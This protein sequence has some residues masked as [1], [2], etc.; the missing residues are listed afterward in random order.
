ML[1]DHAE[2]TVRGG[3]G[4]GAIPKKLICSEC[5][6]DQTDGLCEHYGSKS[7]KIFML[8]ESLE[9]EE[10]SFV[11]KPADPF[12]KIVRIHD[13]IMEEIKIDRE[14]NV[15]DC[16]V[17]VMVMKDFFDSTEKTI[18]C[19]DNICTIINQ[20][21]SIM[22]R[23]ADEK[24]TSVALADE[25]GADKVQ[26]LVQG[27]SEVAGKLELTDELTDRQFA[28]VQKT[29]DGLKRRFPLHD[30]LNVRVGLTLFDSAMDL[31]DSE[32]EKV[33]TALEKTAKK[34]GVNLEDF[35]KEQEEEET[36]DASITELLDAAI[37]ELETLCK[38]EATKAALEKR[39]EDA[40]AT[41]E[42]KIEDPI[43]R[44]FGVLQSLAMDF[45]YAG[46]ALEGSITS[47][48]TERGKAAIA[49]DHKDEIEAEITSLKDQVKEL[50]EDVTLLD[51]QNRDLNY[52]IRATLVDEI[53]SSRESLGILED[54]KEAEKEK[55]SK[56]NYDA[57]VTQVNDYRHMKVKLKDSTVNNKVD[58]KTIAD[59][60]L[61]DSV[62]TPNVDQLQDGQPE[63]GGKKELSFKEQVALVK[64]C[65]RRR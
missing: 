42:K 4:G 51:E 53:I 63:D 7:N 3:H 64:A 55:F 13:G 62:E 12:G 26:P 28:L 61:A 50:E 29:E 14:T 48:L 25:F 56:F 49:K 32:K 18:V 54:S 21:D 58:I 41:E 30:E 40:E 27:M 1:I 17:D 23:K 15:L 45:R 36:K 6:Q 19:V 8:A 11:S 20:E 38:D 46:A 43:T 2:I 34:L 39:L 44:L 47:Y 33:R 22:A 5:F 37:S 59:P 57:L 9:Y 52:Q 65:F 16:D 31:T 35:V 60:T 24:V 10:L